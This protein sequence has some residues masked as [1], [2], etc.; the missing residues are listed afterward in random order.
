MSKDVNVAYKEQLKS[1]IE[2]YSFHNQS[3]Q[4]SSKIETAK[5]KFLL[6]NKNFYLGK[7]INRMMESCFCSSTFG[8]GK[9]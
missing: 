7:V 4:Q 1:V 2:K 6:K 8:V 9:I 5:E 3:R